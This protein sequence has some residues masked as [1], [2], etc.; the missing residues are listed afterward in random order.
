ML[1]YARTNNK[2]NRVQ[3]TTR[4]Q[5]EILIHR[6]IETATVGLADEVPTCS[7]EPVLLFIKVPLL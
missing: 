3:I 2:K 7:F 5:I 1:I 6:K 4:N